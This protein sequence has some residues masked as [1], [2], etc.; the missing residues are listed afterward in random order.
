[1]RRRQFQQLLLRALDQ[2]PPRFRDAID[3]LDIEVRWRPGP[4]ER[5]HA[6]VRSGHTLL[7]LYLGVPLTERSS[8]YTLTLPD[9]IVVY[10]EPHELACE[11]EAQLVEQVRKTLLHEIGHYL[12]IEE[13]RL[14]ELGL[15]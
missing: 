12:G 9:K 5:R 1:M 11:T 14:G 4:Q 13:D 8:G 7:G 3:N 10:Q 2:L 6:G 15:G